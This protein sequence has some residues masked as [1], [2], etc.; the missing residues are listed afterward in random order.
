[1]IQRPQ[2]GIFKQVRSNF[3]NF[4]LSNSARNKKFDDSN[5]T[6]FDFSEIKDAIKY[7]S[8]EQLLE[9][10]S[11]PAVIICAVITFIT[12]LYLIIGLCTRSYVQNYEK[13]AIEYNNNLTIEIEEV[14]SKLMDLRKTGNMNEYEAFL[15]PTMKKYCLDHL[16]AAYLDTEAMESFHMNLAETVS[17]ITQGGAF[18]QHKSLKLTKSGG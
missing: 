7:G 5:K 11:A 17:F 12:I 18:K 8:W 14:L 15:Q 16:E 9:S 1:M 3:D 4:F 13:P 2:D 6:S 10:D